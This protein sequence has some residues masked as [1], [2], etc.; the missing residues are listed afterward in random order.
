MT[1]QMSLFDL[2]GEEE[3]KD[4][5]IPL[6]NVGEYSKEEKLAYEK[7]VLGVYLTGHPLEDYEAKWK[8]GISRTTLDFQIDEESGHSKVMDGTKEI[9]G[10]I[11]T[12]KT[13]KYTKT[14]KVMAFLTLE[15]LVGTVEIVVFPRD[16]EKNQAYLNEDSKVFIKGRVSEED[17]APSKLICESVIPFEKTKKEIWIQYANKQA[18]QEDESQ[19]FGLL[20]ESEGDD[21]IVIYCK[22]E[23]QIKR[24]PAG[25][26]IHADA[27]MLNKM[28][29]FYGEDSIRVVEK[30]MDYM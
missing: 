21:S 3:K 7:E 5:D 20:A 6:P 25:R 4:F 2:V 11:I 17:D 9:V 27:A 8:K 22:E 1:G 29:N 23:R 15:D 10:G 16:Y 12:A 28:M 26:N 18:Y 14:N 19:L 13:I 24:L 30:T